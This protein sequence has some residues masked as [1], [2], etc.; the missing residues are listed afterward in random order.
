MFG[1]KDLILGARATIGKKEACGKG[2][3]SSMQEKKTRV[4]R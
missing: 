4:R 2:R 1:R 3:K